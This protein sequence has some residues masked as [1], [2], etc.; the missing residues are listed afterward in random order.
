MKKDKGITLIAVIITIIVLIILAGIS[1]IIVVRDNGLIDKTLSTKEQSNKAYAYERVYSEVT[2]SRDSVG[3]INLDKLNRNLR[4]NLEKIDLKAE[5]GSYSQ[6][7][8]ENR[9]EQ[10]P[11]TVKYRGYDFYINEE[12]NVDG[13]G[14]GNPIVGVLIPGDIATSTEKNNYKDPNGDTATM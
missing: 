3:R 8:E 4:E 9:I 7:T 1:I 5:D 11:I 12:N 6:L 13:D 14:N 10:L 2:V